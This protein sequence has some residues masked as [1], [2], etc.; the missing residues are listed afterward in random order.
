MKK[1]AA[2][3]DGVQLGGTAASEAGGVDRAGERPNDRAAVARRST[4]TRAQPSTPSQESSDEA[5]G[6]EGKDGKDG[7]QTKGYGPLATQLFRTARVEVAKS[8][9]PSHSPGRH[10]FK[11]GRHSAIE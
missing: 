7:Q 4:P 9:S 5:K 8:R 11:G 3:A 10:R 1:H 6:K 2:V